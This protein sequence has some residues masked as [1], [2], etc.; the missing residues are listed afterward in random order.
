MAPPKKNNKKK[1]SSY[2]KKN[3]GKKRN[4]VTIS[5]FPGTFAPDEITTK[6]IYTADGTMTTSSGGIYNRYIRGNSLYDPEYA[7][8]GVQPFGFDQL[9]QIYAFYEVYAAKLIWRV[10]Q[11]GTGAGN[12]CRYTIVPLNATQF[13]GSVPASVALASAWPRAKTKISAANGQGVITVSSFI[14]T[15]VGF[16][17][18]N[19]DSVENEAP[20]GQNPAMAWYFGMYAQPLDAASTQSAVASIKVIYYCRFFTRV[21]QASTPAMAAVTPPMQTVTRPGPPSFPRRF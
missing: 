14:T 17:D 8:G 16:G 2:K 12:I 4:A 21:S 9:S 1:K 7:A 3:Y 19:Y 6:L 11:T 10:A 13:A 18:K 20:I 5:S 15:K